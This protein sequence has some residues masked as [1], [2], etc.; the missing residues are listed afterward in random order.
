MKM[1]T[2]GSVLIFLAVV[3]FAGLRFLP[4][5]SPNPLIETALNWRLTQAALGV[6]LVG[7]LLIAVGIYRDQ[8]R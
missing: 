2:A 4:L 6:G 7:A 5:Q 8:R 3:I 1:M